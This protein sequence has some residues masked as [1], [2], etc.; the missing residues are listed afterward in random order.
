MGR[1][2]HPE[3][4]VQKI[5][6]AGA[7]LFIQKGYDGATLQDI[8]DAT[9][10]SKGAIYHHFKSKEDI[11]IRICDRI[12]EENARLLSSVRDDPSLTGAQKLKGIF[13]TALIDQIHNQLALLNMMPYLLD[14]SRFLGIQI[15]SLYDEV[16]P[17]YIQPILEEGIADGSIKTDHPAALAEA[18]VILTEIWMHPLIRPSTPE[19]VRARCAVFRQ[20]SYGL[21]LEILDDELTERYVF[22]TAQLSHMRRGKTDDH[23][24]AQNGL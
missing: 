21:G 7:Q 11:F 10:L 18:I 8:M 1:S 22:L 17:D 12:G 14:N 6:D 20:I 4:T 2:K 23:E 16:A 9:G 13:R 15:A 5:M 24:N 19:E 3:E